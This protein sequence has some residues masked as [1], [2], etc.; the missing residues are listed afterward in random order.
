MCLFRA[1][2]FMSLLRLVVMSTQTISISREAHEA[3][4]REK[5]SD[6]GLSETILR[7]IKTSKS[8][9]SIL[10]KKVLQ[11]DDQ[12]DFSHGWYTSQDLI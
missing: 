4:L 11:K 1:R 9:N 6:E 2:F 12:S 3:L 5:R 8:A 10:K 7:L